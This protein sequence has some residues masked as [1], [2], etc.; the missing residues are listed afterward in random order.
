MVQ[1]TPQPSPVPSESWE[2]T[3]AR[4]GFLAIALLASLIPLRLL[5]LAEGGPILSEFQHACLLLL[6][7]AGPA[8]LW[9]GYHRRHGGEQDAQ[10][11]GLAGTLP[12]LAIVLSGLAATL[13]VRALL[14]ELALRSPTNGLIAGIEAADIFGGL[15]LPMAAAFTLVM[16]PYLPMSLLRKMAVAG[17]L[18]RVAILIP[19]EFAILPTTVH[20]APK[21]N[22]ETPAPAVHGRVLG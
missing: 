20:A 10:G 15:L 9:C 19:I 6:A 7:I 12:L 11:I 17:T 22:A 21:G 8:Y 3:F 18:L 16:L 13:A 2:Q 4:I 14:V 5:K 1:N